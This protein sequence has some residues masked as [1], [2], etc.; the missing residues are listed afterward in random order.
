MRDDFFGIFRAPLRIFFPLILGGA[1]IAAW[2]DY[3]GQV[4]A[5]QRLHA[6]G[7]RTQAEILSVVERSRT[8]DPL[9]VSVSLPGHINAEVDVDPV[10]D[11]LTSGRIPVVWCPGQAQPVMTSRHLAEGPDLAGALMVT[12][13]SAALAALGVFW[14]FKPPARSHRERQAPK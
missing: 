14:V 12:L 5:V 10:R 13:G 3:S 9:V 11:D 2:V 8:D 6:C 1:I 7:E 4:A